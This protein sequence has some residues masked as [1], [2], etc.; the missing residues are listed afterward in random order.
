MHVGSVRDLGLILRE[1]RRQHGLNQH[2]LAALIGVSRQWVALVETGRG[3]PGLAPVI[4]ALRVLDMDL[5]VVDRADTADGPAD[6]DQL[7]GRTRATLSP[8]GPTR[9]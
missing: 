1:A 5:T 6:L 4:E 3:N 8:D 9:G 7:L 2:E